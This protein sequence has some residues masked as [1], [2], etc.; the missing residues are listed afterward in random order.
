M[1]TLTRGTYGIRY[2]EMDYNILFTL[3]Y[4]AMCSSVFIRE[5]DPHDDWSKHVSSLSQ[6]DR[7]SPERVTERDTWGKKQPN[8]QRKKPSLET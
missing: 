4:R 8:I 5:D 3:A 6:K 7:H 1:N 2:S